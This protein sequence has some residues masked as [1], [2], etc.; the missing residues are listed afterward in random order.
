MIDSAQQVSALSFTREMGGSETTRSVQS[1]LSPS[2]TTPG[3]ETAGNPDFGTTLASIGSDMVGSLREA[4]RASVA[5]IV[6]KADT[7]EVV[8]AVM[9]AEQTLR[10]AIAIRDKIVQSYLEISRMQ[11]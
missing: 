11:I 5:G 8:D 1:E 4:E 3:A 6:G 9:T 7:R 2:L 10:T